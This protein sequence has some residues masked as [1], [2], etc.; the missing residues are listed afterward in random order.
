VVA[1]DGDRGLASGAPYDRVIATMSVR[2]GRVPYAWVEQTRPGGVIVTPVRADLA[3]GPLV[4][5]TVRED[6]TATGRT[7]P[8][9]VGFMESRSQRQPIVDED[10]DWEREAAVE[11]VTRIRPGPLLDVCH[12]PG[13]RWRWPCHPA[14]TTS[15]TGGCG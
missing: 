6:G 11:R 8:M 15:G 1:G 2:L 13:G 5:F 7:L 10:I 14:V 4:A 12:R 3:S 9:G